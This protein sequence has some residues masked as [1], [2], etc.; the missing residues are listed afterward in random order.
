LPAC[1]SI[2]VGVAARGEA[3]L[4]TR[5]Y[6]G[7]RAI[8]ESSRWVHSGTHGKSSIC[9]HIQPSVGNGGGVRIPARETAQ[10]AAAARYEGAQTPNDPMPAAARE[11]AS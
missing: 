10:R 3:A 1:R 6:R 4:L 8:K 11:T 5:S 7:I 2:F 9:S